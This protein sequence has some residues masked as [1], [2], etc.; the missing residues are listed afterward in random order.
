MPNIAPHRIGRGRTPGQGS[1]PRR[2]MGRGCARIPSGL[3]I[4]LPAGQYL[5]KFIWIDTESGGDYRPINI[6]FTG[7]EGLGEEVSLDAEPIEY[8]SDYFTDEV[9]DIICKETNRYA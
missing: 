4:D 6:P 3:Q 7:V 8:L 5:P 2:G 9:A 1:T